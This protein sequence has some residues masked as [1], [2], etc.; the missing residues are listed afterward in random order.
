M[1]AEEATMMQRTQL[2]NEEDHQHQRSPSSSLRHHHHGDAKD[3]DGGEKRRQKATCETVPLLTIML[4][5]EE[6]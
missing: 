1:Q 3:H 4:V 6:E 5:K 2:G